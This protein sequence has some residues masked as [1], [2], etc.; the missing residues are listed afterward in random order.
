MAGRRQRLDLEIFPLNYV[1]PPLRK[2]LPFH[3]ETERIGFSAPA[4]LLIWGS[5]YA[6]GSRPFY[7]VAGELNRHALPPNPHGIRAFQRADVET[8]AFM[9]NRHKWWY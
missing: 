1:D 6:K 2:Q 5:R 8:N 4:D 3:Q 7:Q 9:S